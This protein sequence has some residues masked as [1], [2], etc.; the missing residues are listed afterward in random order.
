MKVI[1]DRLYIQDIPIFHIYREE[2]EMKQLPFVIFVHGYTS[3]KEHNLHYAYLLAEKGFRVALPDA[4][5]HGERTEPL[6]ENELNMKFWEI[7][8]HTIHELKV[9]KDYFVQKQLVN[10]NA[11]G[12]AGTSMGGIITLGAL[13]QYSWI[14]SAVCLM[15]SPHYQ[16]F[17]TEQVNKLKSEGNKLPISDEKVKAQI[18]RLFEYDLS[19]NQEALNNR[20]ILF[21]HGKK[22]TVVPFVPTYQFYEDI[23]PMYHQTPENLQFIVDEHA[24]HKVS[25]QGVLLAVNWF[26][27][28]LLQN[29]RN[30]L[31]TSI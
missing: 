29:N 1:V 26:K 18:D 24:G 2:N 28:H 4:K 27:K 19:Q 5:Y 9:I 3:A 31:E 15:G 14:K 22:D 23:K 16:L 7:V 6:T 21:W 13:T 12:V 8:I 17:A 10:P 25:R 30:A 11:I 20:P